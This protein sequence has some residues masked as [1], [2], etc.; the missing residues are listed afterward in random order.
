[1]NRLSSQTSER[2]AFFLATP[3]GDGAE[4][5]VVTLANAICERGLKL[6]L[7]VYQSDSY[8]EQVSKHIRLIN[9]HSSGAMASIPSLVRYLREVRPKAVLSTIEQIN[10]ALLIARR[11]SGVPARIIIREAN[12]TS[13]MLDTTKGVRGMLY[14]KLL[15]ICYLWAD[16]IVAVS[17]G[18]ADNLTSKLHLP[19]TKV[20]VI[21]NPVALD[22]LLKNAS[23]PVDH[24][25]FEQ[26]QPPVVTGVGRLSLQ[27][28]FATLIRAFAQLRSCIKARLLILGEGEERGKLEELARE[29]NVQKDMLLP[30]YVKNPHPY[31][32]RSSLF[33]LSSAFE[34]LP[35]ALIEALAL[36]IPVV[37]TDCES[38]PREILDNGRLGRLVPVADPN[39]LSLAML[40]TLN[41]VEKKPISQEDLSKFDLDSAV[42][43]YIR[44]LTGSGEAP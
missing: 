39:A 31:I 4:R 34:G 2:I 33:V 7:V 16:G 8:R 27:K 5:V 9:L 29:L 1:M 36:G 12:T 20:S 13:R 15:P 21:Y 40:E 37:S 18:V 25:W 30:G 6:D 14:R 19:K 41:Q 3:W 44:M 28:D 43:A 32:A 22:Q 17:Q 26:G 42:D 11:L 10:I 35:N 23:V 24:P 38:G